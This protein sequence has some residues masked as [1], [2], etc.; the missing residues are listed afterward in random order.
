MPLLT[1]CVYP[2]CRMP[3]PR[4]ERY[5]ER[6]QEAGAKR[7]TA[8]AEKAKKYGSSGVCVG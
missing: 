5:C 2:G 6:H 4:G 1:V 3:T 7:D 8:M